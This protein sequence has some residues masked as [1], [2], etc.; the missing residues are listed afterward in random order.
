MNV[1]SAA[2]RTVKMRQLSGRFRAAGER[3]PPDGV[4]LEEWYFASAPRTAGHVSE[5]SAL[6]DECIHGFDD[7]LCA[8]CFP[9]PAPVTAPAAP[10][11]VR[12]P[13]VRTA[14]TRAPRASSSKATGAA[15]T[16]AVHVGDQRIYH[17]THISNLGSILSTG[18]LLA[19]AS[20]AW[21]IR[22]SV[23]ISSTSNREAR[24]RTYVAGQHN[25]SIA[26][27]VPFFLSPDAT[28]WES[29]RSGDS[30][31][32]L[33]SDAHAAAINDFVVLVTTVRAASDAAHGTEEPGRA[34]F[35]V[36]D[37]DAAGGLTRI[38]A[39]PESADRMLRKLAADEDTSALREAEVLVAEALPFEQISVIGVAT[40]NVRETVKQMVADAG[41]RTKVAAYTPWFQTSAE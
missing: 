28:L 10:K 13:R 8:I 30:D 33:S 41:Y 21:G 14:T 31:S 6:S 36:T 26:H 37:G 11:A 18:T 32:R 9:K 3:M 25:A 12:A 40:L 15:K 7:G 27:F 29:I 35:V 38:A 19:D 1:Q 39:T 17:V 24:R 34:D 2:S 5:R 23:D 4:P 20:E 16:S 22:P